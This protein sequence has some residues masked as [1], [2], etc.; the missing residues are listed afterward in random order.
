MTKSVTNP[1]QGVKQ[2][3]EARQLVA[4]L[5]EKGNSM[6][7]STVIEHPFTQQIRMGQL[8]RRCLTEFIRNWFTFAWEI[9]SATAAA[10]HRY[11]PY[12]KTHPTLHDVLAEKIADE[13]GHP[14]PGGHIHTLYPVGEA[15]GL[16]HAELHDARLIPGARALVD[17]HVRLILEGPFPEAFAAQLKEAAVGTWL[18]ILG[19]AVRNHYGFSEAAAGYFPMHDEADNQEHA[20]GVMAHGAANAYIVQLALVEGAAGTRPGFDPDYALE[21]GIGLYGVFLDDLCRRYQP[22]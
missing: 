7:H 6:F 4:Q 19:E 15:V 11:L 18:G 22:V 5:R 8:S 13:L 2:E 14:G 9:N 12:L 17:Y 1:W 10:Y 16:G 21:T 3:E 20:E